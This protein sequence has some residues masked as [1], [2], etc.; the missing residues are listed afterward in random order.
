M[1]L[2]AEDGD[3]CEEEPACAILNCG[4]L[5][6]AKPK[7]DNQLI[8]FKTFIDLFRLYHSVHWNLPKFDDT[9]NATSVGTSNILL[10]V[11]VRIILDD[12]SGRCY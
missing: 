5:L 8:S 9:S 6:C 11:L 7:Q 3:D 4:E 10:L 2:L 1:A 12:M